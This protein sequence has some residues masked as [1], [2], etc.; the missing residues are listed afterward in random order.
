MK[1]IPK[2][3]KLLK[4]LWLDYA[5]AN[6]YFVKEHVSN[7]PKDNI[8]QITPKYSTASFYN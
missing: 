6:E 2:I 3:T 1:F 5:N 8:E 4:K 7:C